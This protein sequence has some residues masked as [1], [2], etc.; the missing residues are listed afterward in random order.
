METD[1]TSVPVPSPCAGVVVAL[2][3]EDGDK[4]VPGQVIF[5]ISTDASAAPKAAPP[6]PETPKEAPP[7]PAAAAPAAAAP[8]GERLDAPKE[9]CPS[10]SSLIESSTVS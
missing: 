8:A 5:K 7:E 9:V 3:V 2:L 4:V 6:A 1:K 10:L